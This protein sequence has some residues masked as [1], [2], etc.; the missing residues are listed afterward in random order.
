VRRLLIVIILLLLAGL[1]ALA[2]DGETVIQLAVPEFL[3]D[4]F[5]EE[6][7]GQFE[8][9]HPGVRVELVSTTMAGVG[10]PAFDDVQAHLEGL[11]EYA[12]SADV[13]LVDNNS[14]SV[15]GTRAGLFMDLTPLASA[16]PELNTDDFLPQAWQSFQ[17][18]RG[19]WALPV[20][21]DVVLLLY[22][23]A[24]FDEAGISY[25][26]ANWTI[27]EFAAAARA[28]T[29]TNENGETEPGFFDYGTSG[30]LLRSLLGTSLVDPT[31]VEST[32]D[33]SNPELERILTVWDELVDEGVV[34]GVGAGAS[35]VLIGG[36]ADEGP[37]MTVQRSFGLATFPGNEDAVPP[38]GSLLPGG[39]AGMDVQGMAVSA[40]THYPELAYEL[41]KFLTNSPEIATQLFG[42]TPAREGLQNVEVE[43]DNQRGPRIFAASM[44]F[45]PEA[46]AIIDEAYAHVLPV[47]EMR[48]VDYVGAAVEA[49]QSN[50]LDA[51]SALQQ[52]E[53]QAIDNLNRAS[54]LRSEMVVAVA[55]PVPQ[56]ALAPGEIELNFGVASFTVP[57]PNEDRWQ[58]IIDQFVA[59]DPE[60]GRINLGT[61]FDLNLENMASQFDCF[62][63]PTNAVPGGNVS[64]IVSLDPYMDADP[65]FDRADIVGGVLEQL[66]FDNHTWAYPMA[67]QPEVLRYNP[68]AFERAGVP[69]PE[70][71]WTVDQFVDALNRLKPTPEDPAPF[72]P[73]DFSGQYLYALITAFGG[74]P[75][76]NRTDPPTINFTDPSTVDAIRQVLDLAKNGYIEYSGGNEPGGINVQVIV[77]GEEDTGAIYTHTLSAFGFFTRLDEEGQIAEDNYQ[78]VTYPRGSQYTPIAFDINTAYIS[79]SAANPEAC[80]RWISELSKHPDLFSAMP[81]RRSLIDNPST[82][83]DL[84]ALYHQIDALMSDP[85]VIVS[86]SAL[87]ARGASS[88]WRQ[89]WLQRAFQRYIEDDADLETELAQAEQFTRDYETCAAGIPQE[90]PATL[91]DDPTAYFQQFETCATSVDPTA[92]E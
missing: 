33:F 36:G 12:S 1:P 71:G 60:V 68:E 34:A 46:Q 9:Q 73:R 10:T 4:V 50:D 70:N 27:D 91:D 45:S 16:D 29:K 80:Y 38:S 67:I 31:E 74:I 87:R 6:V 78:L 24:A 65:Q 13:L 2:Q 47:A 39:A 22:N 59:T 89:L 63:L 18:D 19:I 84:A 72:I 53:A 44:N 15:E 52:A 85:N 21:V 86:P 62:Y 20:G 8:A 77:G 56:T 35:M 61:D 32:P 66:R 25:P 81:A 28:L 14:L 26:D 40:G 49:M 43:V 58:Q 7:L 3:K 5:S 23:P 83:P 41:A 69:L 90:E 92:L 51:A 54:E 11:Q 55:T 57:L 17:W 88:I 82:S 37:P 76:D 48:F 64:G 79:A 30:Y 42:S 75:I